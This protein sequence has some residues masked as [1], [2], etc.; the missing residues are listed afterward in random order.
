MS[1]RL[2]LIKDIEEKFEALIEATNDISANVDMAE[3]KES[4]NLIVSSLRRR[5]EIMQQID[6][7]QLRL[8][9][10]PADGQEAQEYEKHLWLCHEMAKKLQTIDQ[11]NK[12][13]LSRVMN[14]YMDNVRSTKQSIR[15][16]Q[17]YNMQ[18][19]RP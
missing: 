17:A 10:V 5:G 12:Q 11:V 8:K 16:L 6:S 7:L 19:T 1:E 18:T 15:T 14:K 3:T 13:T 2:N 4:L 9:D